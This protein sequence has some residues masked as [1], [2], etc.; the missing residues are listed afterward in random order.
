MEHWFGFG[1]RVAVGRAYYGQPPLHFAGIVVV[2][3]QAVLATAMVPRGFSKSVTAGVIVLVMSGSV[4]VL[5]IRLARIRTVLR[6]DGILVASVLATRFVPWERMASVEFGPGRLDGNIGQLALVDGSKI[7]LPGVQTEA[8][9]REIAGAVPED[10][11]SFVGAQS[12]GRELRGR[13]SRLV[14]MITLVVAA[15][16]IV[17]VTVDADRSFVYL[18]LMLGYALYVGQRH[19]RR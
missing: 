1:P 9:T 7:E 8:A 13:P 5:L 15:A 12:A 18:G 3:V 6:V 11:G 19:N 10:A 2:F 14:V 4:W 16:C 17:G